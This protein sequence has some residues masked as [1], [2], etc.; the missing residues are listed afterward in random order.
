MGGWEGESEG[1]VALR[2]P[3]PPR[4]SYRHYLISLRPVS[5]SPG[6]ERKVTLLSSLPALLTAP[7]PMRTQ[8]GWEGLEGQSGW[9][10]GAPGKEKNLPGPLPLSPRERVPMS[11]S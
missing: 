3:S 7:T 11:Q 8:G 6:F 1:C 2:I 5:G 9:P 10:E 4:S